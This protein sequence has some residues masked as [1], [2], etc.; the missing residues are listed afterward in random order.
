MQ[1]L[2]SIK[3]MS[4][5]S[6]IKNYYIIMKFMYCLADLGI[7]SAPAVATSA[8]KLHVEELI[9]IELHDGV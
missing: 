9:L 5:T 8:W 6:N 3:S 4:S 1:E 7:K 2:K